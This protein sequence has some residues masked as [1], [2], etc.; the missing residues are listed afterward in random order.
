MSV[1]ITNVM[2]VSLDGRIGKHALESDVERREYNFTNE[3][4]REWV[5]D[6]LTQADAV[7]TGAN[8]LR[9]SGRAWDVKNDHGRCP[10]WVVLSKHGLDESLPFWNQR[11]VDRVLVSSV[12]LQQ[13]LCRSKDV[14]SWILPNEG[15]ASA[16]VKRLES[17]KLN[18]VLLF[19]GGAI[20]KLFYQEGLVDFAKITLSPLIIGGLESPHFVDPG[21]PSCIKMTLMSSVI[22]GSLVFLTYQVQ[23]LEPKRVL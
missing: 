14:T 8:S 7:V 18:R 4:D 9:A 1:V 13:D 10:T 11:N 12:E 20:N 17:Q 22:K 15:I 23:K 19:G 21:L 3:D 2:A 16:L 6:L 5:R